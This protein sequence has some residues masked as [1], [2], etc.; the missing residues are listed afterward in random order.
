[1]R[2]KLLLSTVICTI[3][4]VCVIFSVCAAGFS[5]LPDSH[6]AY[7]YIMELSSEGV[8]NGYSD[9]TFRPEAQVT[10]A[11]FVKLIGKTNDK[12]AEDFA[13]LPKT[14]WAYDYVMNSGVDMERRN[15]RPDENIT[16]AEV[17]DI[18]WKRYGT[19]TEIAV[20]GIISN[21]HDDKDAV[22]WAY[23][24]GL[25]IGDNGINLRLTDDLS[26]AE[27]V[28][29]ILR[30]RK[31][32]T[33]N[34]KL[35][36]DN[37]AENLLEGMF[38]STMAFDSK[39]DENATMTVGELSRAALRI[40]H[41][42]HT[43][44]YNKDMYI[45]APDYEDEYANDVAYMTNQVFVKQNNTKE[46]ATKPANQQEAIA[47]LMYGYMF[48]ANDSPVIGRMDDY[49]KDITIDKK[50]LMKNMLLTYTY[51]RGVFSS[52]DGLMHDDKAVTHKE[53]A[54]ILLQLDELTGSQISYAGGK[55]Q[56]EKLSQDANLYKKADNDFKTLLKG[57]P[58]AVYTTPVEGS[59]AEFTTFSKD[60][61]EIFTTLSDG[62]AGK[63]KGR[64][65][66]IAIRTYPTLISNAGNEVVMRVKVF[67]ISN[68]NE[69]GLGEIIGKCDM[70]ADVIARA[71]GTYIVDI[72]TNAPLDDMYIDPAQVSLRRIIW[73][74]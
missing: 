59:A 12:K 49:Y 55:M 47:M 43:I 70:A 27:A 21:Q 3:L 28:T 56:D 9:G 73:N 8:I 11:E 29:L 67:V 5:D 17:L 7:K 14:H 1:M 71:N 33:S 52:G 36:A 74:D 58:E 69:M 38:N 34:Q 39:Y 66:E 4:S 25:M 20:P 50:E 15:F 24:Y 62:V 22:A 60:F 44:L 54:S 19:K 6:W 63:A 23:S 10:R 13:D 2:K 72:S 65:A 31:I 32:D 35:L 46:F 37:V 16:R 30:S 40:A 26:R 42:T 61:F 41:G 51:R 57:L 45:E 68:P 64:G 48:K 53:I 18:L